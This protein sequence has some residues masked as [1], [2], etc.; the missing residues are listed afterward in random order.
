MVG[1]GPSTC[2]TAE[3]TSWKEACVGVVGW[4][5]ETPAPVRDCGIDGAPSEVDK[6]SWGGGN[7]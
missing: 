7:H 2:C 4:D 3:T 6:G 5:V 1:D